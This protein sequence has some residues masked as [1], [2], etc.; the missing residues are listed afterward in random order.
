MKKIVL[1][2]SSPRRSELLKQIGLE[3][4]IFPADIDEGSISG[5]DP[6]DI[7]EKLSCEKANDVGRRLSPGH[8][9]IG[10]DTIVVMG[11]S[12]LG[13]PQS[14]NHAA[15]ILRTLSGGWHE[16]I[17][18]LTVLDTSTGKV[19]TESEKTRVKMKVISD[20]NIAAYIATGEP[21]DK[22]GAYGI[23]GMGALFVEKIEGCY[24]NV[25][26]LPIQRLGNILEDF[27]VRVL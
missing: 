11:D 12:I 25:V 1:A 5:T 19:R 21:M 22:A 14:Q 18:G 27:G 20:N 2:S 8:L 13:K 26:G 24:F 4:D 7:V 9:V 6:Q 3:F 10:A 15:E 23:Q 17:T 16:V